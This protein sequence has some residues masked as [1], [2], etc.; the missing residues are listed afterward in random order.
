MLSIAQCA[1]LACFWEVTACKPGNVHRYCD[2]H[3]VTYLDF[4]LSA[5]AIAPVLET[6]SGRGVGETIYRCIEATRELTATNTNLGIVLL[7]APLAITHERAPLREVLHN[8]T[9]DDAAWTYKAIRLAQPGGMGKVEDQDVADEPTQT[10][11]EVMQ[12]AADRDGVAR[13][14]TNGFEQIFDEGVPLLVDKCQ[15]EADLETAI[16]SSYLHLLERHPDTLIARKRGIE[17]AEE[18][19][20]RAGQLLSGE[21]PD[22]DA[23][24][25]WLREEKHSRNPGTTADLITAS[26]FVALRQGQLTPQMPFRELPGRKKN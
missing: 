7:L 24:D 20:R 16:I 21:D 22:W 18:V 17:E 12:L 2:F 23:F 8:L 6:A 26:L 10:L 9:I 3:D 15:Q 5:S 13:Q 19:S 25:A 14:Y 4:I 1:Q 11:L